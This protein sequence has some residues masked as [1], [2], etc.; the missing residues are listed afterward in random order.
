L[1]EHFGCAAVLRRHLEQRDRQVP[2][3][4][5]TE[6]ARKL[7]ALPVGRLG[8]GSLIVCVRDPSPALQT[9][10]ARATKQDVVLAVAPA[11]YVERLV[12]R[13]YADVDVPIEIG[14]A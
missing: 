13:T 8:N 4:L 6:L 7:T 10:L 2:S 3:L 5:R 11:S 9:A 12:A 1:G 14:E